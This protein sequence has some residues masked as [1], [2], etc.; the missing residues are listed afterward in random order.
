MI[1]VLLHSYELVA[2]LVPEQHRKL[3]VH[4]R[5]MN[6]REKRRRLARTE[7]KEEGEVGGA[8]DRIYIKS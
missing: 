7:G 5:K 6:E 2:G 1:C 3:L 4:I 8:L